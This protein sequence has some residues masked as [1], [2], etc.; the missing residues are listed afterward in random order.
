MGIARTFIW[1]A[2]ILALASCGGSSAGPSNTSSVNLATAELKNSDLPTEYLLTS[3][4]LVPTY[5]PTIAAPAGN[6]NCTS[7]QS[8]VTST[9]QEGLIQVAQA[10]QSKNVLQLCGF[11]IN[12][13]GDPSTLFQDT[14]SIVIPSFMQS[15]SAPTIGDESAVAMLKSSTKVRGQVYELVFRH[16]NAVIAMFFSVTGLAP[17]SIGQFEQLGKT[18]NDRMK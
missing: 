2:L 16:G 4:T 10:L 1:A 12:S 11:T 5:A 14:K 7:P 15:V 13:T 9:W 6:F 3:T 17:W 18:L 8:L